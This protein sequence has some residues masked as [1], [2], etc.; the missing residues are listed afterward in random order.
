MLLIEFHL[1]HF[2]ISCITADNTAYNTVV[3]PVL[4]HIAQ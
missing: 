2:G 4:T 1:E 3:G